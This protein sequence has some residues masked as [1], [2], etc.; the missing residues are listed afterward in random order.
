MSAEFLRLLG[1]EPAE[2]E[3]KRPAAVL[4]H[5]YLMPA[6]LLALARHVNSIAHE[7]QVGVVGVVTEN[8]K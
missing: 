2:L 6:I 4:Y 3:K 8:G 7:L 5:A 1:F